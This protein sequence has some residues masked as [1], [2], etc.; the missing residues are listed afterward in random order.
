MTNLEVNKENAV[1]AYTAADDKT[2]TL[3]ANLFGKKTFITDTKELIKTF[4]D[5]C[6]AEGIDYEDFLLENGHLPKDEYA[7]KQLKII[8]KA[9]NGGE[10]LDYKDATVTKYYPYFYSAGSGSGFSFSDAYYVIDHSYVGSRLLLKTSAL[11]TYA[12][13]Q[14]TEIYSQ[15]LNA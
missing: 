6:E 5:A 14:F 4:E 10:V 12:G 15:Y 1:K 7:Y 9:L 2:K 8:V 13:K 11:A 3:L